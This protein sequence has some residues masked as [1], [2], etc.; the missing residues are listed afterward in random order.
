MKAQ[1]KTS[2]TLSAFLFV[3]GIVLIVLH[4]HP[5]VSTGIVL[6]IGTMFLIPGLINVIVAAFRRPS[7]REEIA[8]DPHRRAS[9]IWGMVLSVFCIAL[10]AAMIIAAKVF[11]VILVYV[12][13]SVLIA[14]GFYHLLVIGV[15]ARP[16]T[17]PYYF[18]IIPVLMIVAGFVM[19]FSPVVRETASI[20]LLIAGIAFVG[21]AVNS[22]LEHV[23]ITQSRL[24]IEEKN[25]IDGKTTD[26]ESSSDH[27]A[28]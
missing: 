7:K 13:A 16:Y 3:A 17:M 20:F 28:E 8:R 4:N 14:G 26:T 5:T 27:A 15:F 23:G 9:Y 18:N 1:G 10:G 12:F 2:F 24:V 25:S 11:L 22:L 21:S 19:F 6:F